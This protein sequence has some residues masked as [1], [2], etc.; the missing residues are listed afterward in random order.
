MA[1]SASP[2]DQQHTI[3]FMQLVLMF[4]TAAIQQ[5]GK[6]MNPVTQKVERDLQQAR[7]SIDMLAMLKEKT[8]GNLTDEETHL[9][10]HLLFELRMNYI[11]EVK[12]D[13]EKPQAE[14]R[15]AEPEKGNQEEAKSS[16]G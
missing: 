13:Q 2:Q 1:E 14:S 8:K 3:L 12:A 16:E 4:Q 5:L 9:L 7:M 10:D 6:L 11:D 15:P